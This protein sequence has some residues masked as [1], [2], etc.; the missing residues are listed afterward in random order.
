MSDKN[1]NKNS[2]LSTNHQSQRRLAIVTGD[3]GG[4]GKSTFARGL[5]Q[6]YINKDLA[7][8]AYE[9]DQRNPQLARHYQDKYK[10]LMR[11]VD[12]FRKGQADKLL[13]DIDREKKYPIFLIDLP[14]Q[15]GGF[16]EKYVQE[17]TFFEMLKEKEI[18]CRVTIV[19]VI[20]RV[21]DSVTVLEGLHDLCK[22]QVD[23]VVVKNLFHGE[24]D[25]FER[26]DNSEIRETLLSKGLVEIMMPD[27][28]YQSYDFIDRH[29]L[30][31]N[32][33]L[34]HPE[35]NIAIRARVGRW[36]S[37]FEEEIKPAFH[38]L[39]LNQKPIPGYYNKMIAETKK[40]EKEEKEKSQT[41][42]PIKEKQE[43]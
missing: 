26:Y 2:S 5:L 17:L 9:A 21:L 4:V 38:L 39:G 35:T 41:N 40:V 15:S 29:H 34:T 19:S 24:Q 37:E 18:N 22:D 25:K 16:F 42:V 32:D 30:T 27:L 6:L 28:F 1:N 36:I 12:I 11:Y 20:S 43:A 8:L 14:A 13:I 33:A 31:F 3:K 23:Y 10:F 7:C